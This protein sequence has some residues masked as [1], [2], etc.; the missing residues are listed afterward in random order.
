[1]NRRQF[2]QLAALAPLYLKQAIGGSEAFAQSRTEFTAATSGSFDHFEVRGTYKEIGYEI[3]KRFQPNIRQVVERRAGWHSGLLKTLSSGKGKPFSD[4]LIKLTKKHFPH[5]LEEIRAM[6]DGAGVAFNHL[7]AMCIKSELGALGKE[8]P[9]CSS[10]FIHDGDNM[11]LFHNEDGHS[12]YRDLMFTLKV[13]P[14]SGTSFISMVYPG[15]ITGNG[16]SI[17]DRGVVQM[18]N[19][20]GST[21]AEAG[22]PR[23]V[24]GRAILEARSTKEAIEIATIEPRAYPYHHHIASI[25]EKKYF[26]VETTPGISQVEEPGGFLCH[27]NHLVFDKTRGYEHEDK[28]YRST[29]S[30][31]RYM[32]IEERLLPLMVKKVM[33][34]GPLKPEDLLDILSSHEKAPY[35]CCRHPEGDVQ[36][37]TLGA[38][39]VDIK[40]GVFRLYRGNPCT[41]V[42]GGFF[43]EF[44]FDGS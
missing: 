40:K 27:T 1:M 44:D 29:S 36:G 32:T 37:A 35:S 13:T 21:R 5:V 24:I 6:A 11:W 28:K 7:W 38:A 30:M 23:Y 16:P 2:L 4:E 20:I 15:I 19:Y 42:R 8:P 22:I 17:N 3:G 43:R 41:A 31:P 25:L 39:F 33:R 18:T 10:I 34:T 9:G 14:P 26:A 12:A